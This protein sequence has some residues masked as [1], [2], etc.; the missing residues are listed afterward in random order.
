MIY[1]SLHSDFSLAEWQW[2]STTKLCLHKQETQ[3]VNLFVKRWSLTPIIN[4][5]KTAALTG[6][7]IFQEGNHSQNRVSFFQKKQMFLFTA[8]F[9]YCSVPKVPLLPHGFW[10]LPLTSS[11][12]LVYSESFAVLVTHSAVDQRASF[13]KQIP[14]LQHAIKIIKI[15]NH[16]QVFRLLK[17]SKHL[18]VFV[19]KMEILF[20]QRKMKI[21]VQRVSQDW[22]FPSTTRKPDVSAICSSGSGYL[23]HSPSIPLSGIAGTFQMERWKEL[24]LI[25]IY[26]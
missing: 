25:V 22:A 19:G 4:S 21:K 3:S 24:L 26:G 7:G 16:P 10:Q 9:Q 14:K 6:H 11:N 5:A 13:L 2:F 15:I 23:S 8:F 12:R 18:S 20:R 17:P 1:N